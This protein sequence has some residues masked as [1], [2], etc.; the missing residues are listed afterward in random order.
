MEEIYK[1]V[2]IQYVEHRNNFVVRDDEKEIEITADSMKEAKRKLDVLFTRRKRTKAIEGWVGN[3][4]SSFWR[5]ARTQAEPGLYGRIWVTYLDNVEREKVDA[6]RFVPD[7]PANAAVMKIIID[8][9]DQ[10]R[11]LQEKIDAE[12]EKITTLAG[13]KKEE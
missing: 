11:Q 3:Y 10:R 2:K 13:M 8:L 5:R 6:N 9:C 12:V 7:T 4:V 1:G